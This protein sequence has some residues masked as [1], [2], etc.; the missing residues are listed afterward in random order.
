VFLLW[1]FGLRVSG[2]SFVFLVWG[3]GFR[4]MIS[5]FLFRV[6]GFGFGVWNRADGI[7]GLVLFC[8]FPHLKGKA[9]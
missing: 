4:V 6:L 9:G 5:C 7:L 2:N 3:S 8:E 1:G